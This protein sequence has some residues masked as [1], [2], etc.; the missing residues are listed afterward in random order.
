MKSFNSTTKA[1]RFVAFDGGCVRN[2]S[3]NAIASFG[4]YSSDIRLS[5]RVDPKTYYL[6]EDILTSRG[7]RVTPTNN[8]GEYL[9]LIHALLH[10]LPL[11][12]EKICLVSDS[13]LVIRTMTEWLPKWKTQ[14]IVDQK[15][16]P[17]LVKI[18]DSLLRSVSLK[19]EVEFMHVNSHTK[20][21]TDTQSRA[22]TLWYHNDQADKL[23]SAALL[24]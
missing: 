22:Y 13:T 20:P 14:G 15:K 17:D 5:G 24:Q 9:G 7:P 19:N 21:P 12:G 11:R 6:S 8:R 4:V 3:S 1:V 2:G 10:L 23:A 16:N 18:A